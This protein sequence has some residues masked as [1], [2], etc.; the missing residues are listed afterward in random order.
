MRCRDLRWT[1]ALADPTDPPQLKFLLRALEQ[2]AYAW[3][4]Y[5][6]G[7]MAPPGARALRCMA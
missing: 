5:Q 6:L 3:I 2:T 1:R 4:T 7:R